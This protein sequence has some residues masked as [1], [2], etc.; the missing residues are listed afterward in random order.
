MS[1]IKVALLEVVV[2]RDA[3]TITPANVLPHELPV[4]HKLFGKENV[5][6]ATQVGTFEVD[7]EL[8]HE[9]LSAKYGAEAIVAVFGD[10]GGERLAEQVAKNKLK[11]AADTGAGKQAG[12][13]AG[14]DDSTGT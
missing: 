10:D 2:R 5:N 8:E 6:D 4:L 3:Q 12:A 9:R 11:K 13:D 1:K 7:P 14:G